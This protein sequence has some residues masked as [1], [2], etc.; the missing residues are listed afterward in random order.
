MANNL[1]IGME[2][3]TYKK[4]N[5]VFIGLGVLIFLGVSAS[6]YQSVSEGTPVLGYW[7]PPSFEAIGVGI[8]VICTIVGIIFILKHYAE[9][10]KLEPQKETYENQ[11]KVTSDNNEL[12][13]YQKAAFIQRQQQL[14]E[15]REMNDNIDNFLG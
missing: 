13:S 6:I 12:S 8:P 10:P 15:Q 11:E 7:E 2:N 5:R 3:T 14:Q 4:L 1:M 9:K